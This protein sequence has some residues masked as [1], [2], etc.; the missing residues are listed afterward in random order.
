MADAMSDEIVCRGEE[1]E[2][3]VT[4]PYAIVYTVDREIFT[5]KKFSPVAKVAK[6]KRAKI[7]R[8]R[9]IGVRTFE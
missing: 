8:L 5:G 1:Y 9:T 4:S 7:F 2:L 3:P 6:I